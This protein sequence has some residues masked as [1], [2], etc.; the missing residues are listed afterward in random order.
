MQL[1]S[2]VVGA[3]M[4]SGLSVPQLT[5]GISFCGLIVASNSCDILYFVRMEREV[6][7][8]CVSSG[9]H[10]II[11]VRRISCTLGACIIS[12]MSNEQ[13]NRVNTPQSDRAD[14]G[15]RLRSLFTALPLLER[16]P[17]SMRIRMSLD[18][19]SFP[20]IDSMGPCFRIMESLS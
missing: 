2:K 3:Y 4:E 17:V 11:T 16:L 14:E 20:R 18:A 15:S 5:L 9:S 6:S 10:V 13:K 1:N 7:R 8:C 19:A 12:T